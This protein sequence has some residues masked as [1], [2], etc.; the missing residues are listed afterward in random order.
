[1]TQSKAHFTTGPVGLL[2]TALVARGSQSSTLLSLRKRP[3]WRRPLLASFA[4]AAIAS[5]TCAQTPNPSGLESA[6]SADAQTTVVPVLFVYET[7]ASESQPTRRCWQALTAESDIL[8]REYDAEPW[9][10]RHISPL[11]GASMGGVVGGLILKHHASALLAR[12]WML[13]VIAASS[14]AGYV[15]GPGGVAGFVV[16]GA[17]GNKVGKGKLPITLGSAAGGALAGKKL[18]D[19]F[20]PPETPPP[21]VGEADEEI[22]LEI[23]T[24]QEICAAG[25]QTTQ[26]QSVYRVGYQFNGQELSASLTYDPGEALLIDA[27][28]Q[29]TGPARVRVD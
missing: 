10:L 25:S 15:A 28:G 18:W 3:H 24:R 23:F 22:P 6:I 14:A 29:I 1:M 26:V 2:T 4:T 27:S 9:L 21:L 11:V 19:K 13:P 7:L 20:F 12:K 5:A 16:G 8:R 17:I